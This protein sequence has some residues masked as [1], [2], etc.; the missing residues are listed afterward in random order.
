MTADG[1]RAAQLRDPK[2]WE[3]AFIRQERHRA[4]KVHMKYWDAKRQWSGRATPGEIKKAYETGG[5]FSAKFPQF[6]ESPTNIQ[7]MLSWMQDNDLSCTE[8]SSFVSAYRA[9]MAD[10]NSA[11]LNRH[12]NIVPITLSLVEDDDFQV[13]CR[14]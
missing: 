5:V 12:Q 8:L 4:N 9:K 3:A 10:L 2:G 11:K 1:A 7:A 13:I 6:L 14:K